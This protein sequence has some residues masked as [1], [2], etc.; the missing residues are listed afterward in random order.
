MKLATFIKGD[1]DRVGVVIG[2]QIYDLVS[3]LQASGKGDPSTATS[4]AGILASGPGAIESAGDAVAWAK[5]QGG[6]ELVQDLDQVKLRAPIPHPG[7]LFCLAGN[8]AE[9]I[10]EGGGTFVGKEKM[11]P[12]FF[13]KPHTVIIGH[14][15]AIRIPPSAAWADWELELA[16]VI[17]T[18]GRDIKAEDASKYIGGYTIFNDIS[19]RELTFRQHLPPQDGDWFFDWL[20]GKWLDTFGPMGPWLTTADEVAQPDNLGMRLW[21]NGELQQDANSGQMIFS[22]PELIEF[23]SQFVTLQPGD[24]I[25]T[26]TPAGV[27]HSKKIRLQPGDKIR[28]EIETLGVLENSVEA[29]G[30]S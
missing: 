27:G 25:S 9:H 12:R 29:L 19:G 2:D 11:T 15:D 18:A 22:P 21:F 26:G 10:M 5:T 24:L 13:V 16:V 28:G 3:C 7:K 8:Y 30:G 14:G 6:N 1:S 17:G 4:V 20:V 23:I